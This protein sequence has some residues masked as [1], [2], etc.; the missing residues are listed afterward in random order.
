MKSLAGLIVSCAALWGQQAAS[1]VDRPRGRPL[2]AASKDVRTGPA[3]GAALPKF[4]LP[5]QSGKSRTLAS[6]MGKNG[7]LLYFVRSADW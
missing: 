6:L 1:P 2:P 4:S 3:V 5:D 7:L